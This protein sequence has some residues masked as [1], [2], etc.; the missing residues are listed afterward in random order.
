MVARAALYTLVGAVTYVGL[1]E[2][3]GMSPKPFFLVGYLCGSFF[4]FI[5]GAR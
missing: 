5:A 4:G 2:L 3:L 1:T